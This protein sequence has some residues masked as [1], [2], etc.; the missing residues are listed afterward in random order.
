MIILDSLLIGGLKFVF[1][2]IATAVDQEMNDEGSLREELLAA[3]M[4]VELGEME[5]SEFAELEGR[6]LA[7]MRE[8]RDAQRG[9]SGG[10]V[11]L[12]GGF[13]VD[14]TYGGDEES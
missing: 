14:V 11:S 13:E 1:D 6:I 2:K 10:A 3:Q 7:R 4:R 12:G 8:I 9:E 5:E